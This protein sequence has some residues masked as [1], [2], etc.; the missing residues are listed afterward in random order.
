MDTDSRVRR[1]LSRF[2]I[3]QELPLVAQALEALT[4]HAKSE[5]GAARLLSDASVC[6]Q[7]AEA[8]TCVVDCENADEAR[9]VRFLRDMWLYPL[10]VSGLIGLLVGAALGHLL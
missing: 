2:E 10:A 5:E 8:L 7:A 6:R 9:F 3:R 4:P 1:S